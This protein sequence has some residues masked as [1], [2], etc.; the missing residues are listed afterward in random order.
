MPSLNPKLAIGQAR[1]RSCCGPRDFSTSG[2]I[3]IPE[4]QERRLMAKVDDMAKL[5]RDFTRAAQKGSLQIAAGFG[6]SAISTLALA[7]AMVYVATR[8]TRGKK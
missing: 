4:A 5:T 3:L 6:A 1:A 2:S 7:G 8:T